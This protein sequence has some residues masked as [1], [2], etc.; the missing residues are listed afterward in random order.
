MTRAYGVVAAFV[1][2]LGP[3]GI[4][5]ASRKRGRR[6][7]SRRG[8]PKVV[9][10]ARREADGDVPAT[11]KSVTEEPGVGIG[12]EHRLTPNVARRTQCESTAST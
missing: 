10:G 5:I 11:F 6:L 9:R 2:G 1:F 7:S 4:S 3:A 8:R 12:I